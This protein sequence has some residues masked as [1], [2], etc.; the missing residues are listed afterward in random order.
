MFERSE[1]ASSFHASVLYVCSFIVRLCHGEWNVLRFMS[2]FIVILMSCCY[3]LAASNLDHL[4]PRA[5]STLI[6]TSAPRPA[7]STAHRSGTKCLGLRSCTNQIALLRSFDPSCP[8]AVE[9]GRALISW[10]LN[11]HRSQL[12]SAPDRPARHTLL[13]GARAL[14]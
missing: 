11:L 5:S 8:A 9:A 3:A 4:E 13:G 10:H 6:P 2:P 12:R 7:P 14:K 1:F